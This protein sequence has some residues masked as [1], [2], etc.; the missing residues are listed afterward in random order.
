[1]RLTIDEILVQQ[2]IAEQFPRW[3]NLP[4]KAISTSGW[5]R[6]T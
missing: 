6:R 1:M 3:K 2:I 5:D 4:V